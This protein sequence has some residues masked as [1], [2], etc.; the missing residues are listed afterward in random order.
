M[1]QPS[2]S[3]DPM[4]PE[5]RALLERASQ[6]VTIASG[7]TLLR[8]G[9]PGGDLYVVTRGRLE[10][11]HRRVLPEVVLTTLVKGDLIGEISFLDGSPSATAGSADQVAVRTGVVL[12]EMLLTVTTSKTD[13]LLE[14]IAAIQAGLEQL[15]SGGDIVATRK[16]PQVVDHFKQYVHTE[17]ADKAPPVVTAKVL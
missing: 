15:D 2:R 4:T 7:D 17:G 13:R 11:R 3:L 1:I 5:H 10:A 8:R 6:A 12:A 16:A 9:D 14:Q